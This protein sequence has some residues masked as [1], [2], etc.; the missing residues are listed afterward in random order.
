MN[1]REIHKVLRACLDNQFVLAN[2][3]IYAW[4]CDYFGVSK[5]GYSYEIEIK[6][7]K[8]DFLADF[9]KVKKH[10]M[11]E[12]ARA[13]KEYIT[14]KGYFQYIYDRKEFGGSIRKDVQGF[15]EIPEESERQFN[16]RPFCT[17]VYFKKI[18]TPNRFYY[19]VPDGLVKKSEV[20]KYS[21]LIYIKD[22]QLRKV[23]EAPFLHKNTGR[24]TAILLHKFHQL[25]LTQRSELTFLKQE[26]ERLRKIEGHLPEYYET[27]STKELVFDF[28][29]NG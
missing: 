4:E 27:E 25:S 2:T 10:K 21:G 8:S 7:S 29:E 14:T 19:A 16:F 28:G 20:P 6:T 18:F 23:K 15:G 17:Q 12:L 24:L 22:G 3:Y 5:K 11:L 1:E 13:G 26:N 9:K